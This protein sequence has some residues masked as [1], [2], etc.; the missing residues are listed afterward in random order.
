MVIDYIFQYFTDSF[1]VGLLLF[2][3]FTGIVNNRKS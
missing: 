2:G 1:I 3:L